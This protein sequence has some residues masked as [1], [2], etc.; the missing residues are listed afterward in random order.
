MKTS[1][2]MTQ[3]VVTVQPSTTV[4]KIVHLMVQHNISGI[5]VVDPA[6]RLL[7]MVTERDLIARHARVHFPAYIP[8]LESILVLG[9][10]RHF[11]EEIRRALATS[12]G[13]LMSS[14][15]PTVSAETDILD[16][17]TLMFEKGVNPIPVLEQGRV[18]GIISRTDLIKL[19]VH[20]EETEGSQASS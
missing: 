20:E 16:V 12:A 7:G 17:A 5:P 19:M 13:E 4:S 15:V 18:V 6:G 11:E 3:D 14:G 10:R 8:L 9:N 1:D 2:V